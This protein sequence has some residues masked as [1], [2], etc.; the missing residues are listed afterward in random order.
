M[1]GDKKSLPWE[2]HIH[3]EVPRRI[4]KS[5]MFPSIPYLP[6][7][8]LRHS[9]PLY[10]EERRRWAIQST[11]GG[12]VVGSEKLSANSSAVLGWAM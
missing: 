11:R 9:G 4:K 10:S 2:L 7:N 1:G 8:S 12:A 5:G 6:P 3:N